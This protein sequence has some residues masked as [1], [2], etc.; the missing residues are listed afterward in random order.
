MG[1]EQCQPVKFV[2]GIYLG[3]TYSGYAF[4]TAEQYKKNKLDITHNP[5]WH[6]GLSYKAPTSILLQL[7]G[8]FVSFGIEAE[9]QYERLLLEKKRYE[10]QI[11]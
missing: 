1:A 5:N 8:D 2:A 10:L 3:T 9:K 11:L 7:N 6:H 4:S